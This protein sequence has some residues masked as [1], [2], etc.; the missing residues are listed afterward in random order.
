MPYLKI[1]LIISVLLLCFQTSTYAKDITLKWDA[2]TE[3]GLDHYVVYW[4]TDFDPPYANNSEDKGDF[5]DKNTTTYTVTGL[6]DDTVY[7]FAAKAFDTEG[8]ESSYSNVVSTD[9]VDI[10]SGSGGGGGE[11]WG[12]PLVNQ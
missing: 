4:G 1:A 9:E 7:Y 3:L 10:P 12:R 11:T 2:N 8:L 6:S 5:I